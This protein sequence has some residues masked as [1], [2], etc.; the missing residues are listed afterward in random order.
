MTEQQPEQPKTKLKIRTHAVRTARWL[1]FGL[2]GL[3]LLI[4]VALGLFASSDRGSKWLLEF[5]LDRQQ[6][7]TYQYEDGNLIQGIIIKDILV[8]VKDVEVKINRADVHLGWRAVVK[9]E[10]HLMHAN[11]DTVHVINHAAPT[12]KEFEFKELKLPFVLR[13][14]EAYIKQLILQTTTSTTKFYNI[15]LNES[16]WS[17]AKIQLV[18]SSMAM[19][20]LK[21]DNINGYLQLDGKYPLSLSADATIPALENLKMNKLKLVARGDVDTLKAGFAAASPDVISGYMVLHPVRKNVPMFGK[22]YW[23][24]YH[25]PVAPEQELYSELGEVNLDGDIKKLNINVDT[26]LSGKQIPQGY[27]QAK[28]HTDLKQLN[29]EDFVGSLMSGQVELAGLVGWQDG[30]NWDLNGRLN[31]INPKDEVIPASIREFLPPDMSAKLVTKGSMKNASDIIATVDFDRYERWD[32]KL[33]QDQAKQTTNNEKIAQPWQVQVAWQDIDRKFP[34]IG[35]LNSQEGDVDLALSDK[36]Q[37][38]RL[39]TLIR[40]HESSSLPAG[41]YASTLNFANNILNVKDFS[42]T[43][44]HGQGQGR[45]SGKAKVNLPTTKSQLRWQA[46]LLAKRFNPQTISPSAPVNRLDGSIHATGY[47][48]PNKQVIQ[49]KGIDLI[50]QLPQGNKTQT[51]AL[52]GQSTAV[53]LM[54][55]GKSQSGL[56]GF[57]VQYDGSLNAQNYS[58]GPLKINVSGTP[59][60]IKIN[61]LFHQGAAGK[62]DAK[63][64]VNLENGIGW[65]IQAVLDQFKPQYFVGNVS[66]NVTGRVNTSG[67]WSEQQKNI[68]VQNLNLRGNINNKP[69]L[70]KGNLSVSFGEN[71]SFVPQ[72]F[73]AN[74]LVLSYANNILH[75]AGNAQRLQ[76]N[77]NAPNLDELYVGLGGTIKGFLSVQSQPTIQAK[78]NLIAENLSYSDK[79]NVEKVSLIGTLPTGQTA[80][81]LIFNLQGLTS[82]KRRIDQVKA[83]LVGTRQAHLL[84]LDGNND[85]SK[86]YVQMAGGFNAR[87]DWL[88]Q[89]QKGDFNSQRV[90]LTQNQNASIIYRQAKGQITVTAHCWMSQGRQQ[91]QICLDQPLIANKAQGVVSAKMQNLELADFQ[92]FMPSGLALDGQLNGYTHVFWREGQPMDVDA[93]LVTRQGHI[94][95]SNEEG[96]PPTLIEYREVRL[97]AKTQAQ[98][99]ALKLNA[100]SPLLGTG[101]V[102]VLVGTQ[103]ENKSVSGQVALDQVKLNLFKPFIADV[104][105]LDGTLSAAGRLSGTLQQ[106]SFNGEVRLKD[107][108]IAMISVPLNLQNIQLATSIRDTGATLEGAFNAGK[109]VGKITGLATWAGSPRIQLNISGQ[110]LLVAQPPMISASVSPNIDIEIR[111]TQHLLV[112]NGEIKV[113]RAVISMPEGSAN[114]VGTSSDVRVVRSNEDQLAIL[115]ASRP[116]RI[117]ADVALNLGDAVIFRGFNSTIP[118]VGRINLRQRGTQIALQA[119]GAIGVSR[120][121]TIEA[122]GQRLELTRAIARFGGELANPG[123]DIEASKDIQNSTIGVRI[124]GQASSPNIQIYNDAGLTEQEALNALLTGRISSGAGSVNNTEGFKSDVNNTIAA[125]GISMGLGGTRAF[126]NQIGRS[127]GL[128]GLALDAQGSGNDTQVSVTGYITPDLYLRYGV[129]IF[130]PVNTL[131]LRYQ[132]NRRLYLEATSSL[133]R[134]IDVFYN[135]KF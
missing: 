128:S 93:Q 26:D 113:P 21:A 50:G 115:K 108:K 61:E 55:D 121:V 25:W 38:I 43:Q 67:R 41:Q 118:L 63:G 64:M 49:L 24:K 104:R 48:E 14:D 114:V 124:T 110:E 22:V 62:L 91:S 28:M 75:A 78:S 23:S 85:R 111:P 6:T 74:N 87:N 117:N 37:D 3:L 44:G 7:I 95:L 133:E 101:Y 18:N 103:G 60:L 107:G 39:A 82:N 88:G 53:L 96:I 102:D 123:L 58:Q 97:S 51:I 135:W 98:A 86:F 9:K 109:G 73:E 84:K 120:Q 19:D 13:M 116:W 12:D 105:E 46:D 10:I 131:T 92:A 79:I 132:V 11:I 47:A 76:L 66:G 31:G 129:G 83:E 27:Y 4:I 59:K 17:G 8:K 45:L 112:V 130:T 15:Q 57:A 5:V 90:R 94:G 106:P 30:V 122:Y 20:F 2:L 126:T 100:D 72:Q 134:A 1:V 56:R 80:S 42:L 40:E 65:D 35:W 125:A 16:E 32:V 71:N 69:L 77:V 89:I 81:Q 29:I 36:G 54:H 99:L 33:H 52:T 70:G 34:Y 119:N 127:F 68:S